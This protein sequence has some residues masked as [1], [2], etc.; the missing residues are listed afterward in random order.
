M[1]TTVAVRSNVD[2]TRVT[3]RLRPRWKW[4]STGLATGVLIVLLAMFQG[5]FGHVVLGLLGFALLAVTTVAFLVVGPTQ[6]E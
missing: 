4:T 1:A 5:P 2:R 6:P 3:T